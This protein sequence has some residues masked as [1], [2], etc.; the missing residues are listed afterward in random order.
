MPMDD[1]TLRVWQH[2]DGTIEAALV[3]P[4]DG[5]G[6]RYHPYDPPTDPATD[7][8]L[9]EKHGLYLAL[10][11][12]LDHHIATS[13]SDARL[14]RITDFT[15]D[16]AT[17][18]EYVKYVDDYGTSDEHSSSALRGTLRRQLG[19]GA[20]LPVEKTADHSGGGFTLAAAHSN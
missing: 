18:H 8:P 10:P 16:E 15:T 11:D 13:D 3:T 6:A 17:G 14:L 4:R 5:I 1:T 19:D 9:L 12:G 20:L 2:A 7:Q